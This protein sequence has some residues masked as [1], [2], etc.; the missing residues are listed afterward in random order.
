MRLLRLFI[1][2]PLEEG[3]AVLLKDDLFHYISNVLRAKANQKVVLFNN[4][5]FD[6]RGYVKN[7]S[8][9]HCEICIESKK[10]FEKDIYTTEI[11]FSICKNPCSDFIIKKLTELGITSI[12][13]LISKNSIF[14][15]K[16]DFEKKYYF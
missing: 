14:N 1:D 2:E 6:F 8:K 15:K 4:S 13:P 3:C 7:I 9:K 10:F 16:L 5:G 12:Q 11:A